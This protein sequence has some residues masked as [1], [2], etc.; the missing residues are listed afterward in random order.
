MTDPA[1]SRIEHWKSRL[2]DLSLRN[3]LLNYR[4]RPTSSVAVVDEV[5]RVVIRRLV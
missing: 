5:P 3:K 4:P 1:I 2:I